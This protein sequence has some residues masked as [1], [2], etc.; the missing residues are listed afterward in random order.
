ML[1]DFTEKHWDSATLGYVIDK[2]YTEYD[3]PI[4]Y[5]DNNYVKRTVVDGNQVETNTIH[6]DS[7]NEGMTL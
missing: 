1:S 2:E 3:F 6:V 7:S 4:Y 5:D